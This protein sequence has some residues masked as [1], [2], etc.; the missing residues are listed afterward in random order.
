[1]C[2]CEIYDVS[3][4]GGS[5]VHSQSCK[6]QHFIHWNLNFCLL[7]NDLRNLHL[8]LCWKS[9]DLSL[10]RYIKSSK[11][12]FPCVRLQTF[13][14]EIQTYISLC[15]FAEYNNRGRGS[16]LRYT[17]S[18]N[19][20]SPMKKPTNTEIVT[21]E[22]IGTYLCFWINWEGMQVHV[23]IM[24][25]PLVTLSYRKMKTAVR[26]LIATGTV[27]DRFIACLC[28]KLS[29]HDKITC[30]IMTEPDGETKNIW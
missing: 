25:N 28:S 23:T 7:S 27:F 18:M 12:K 10:P 8:L 20:T 4:K 3:E 17:C 6:W 16:G 13:F 15:L 29:V 1:M 9:F 22:Y 26:T 21:Q 5:I 2:A 14:Y 19:R 11:C 30:K 24:V